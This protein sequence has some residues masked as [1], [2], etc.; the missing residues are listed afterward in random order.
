MKRFPVECVTSKEALNAL[1]YQHID[2]LSLDVEGHEFEVLNGFDWNT[3]TI[4]VI[5]IDNVNEEIYE[6]LTE[7]GYDYLQTQGRNLDKYH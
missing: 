5:E 6:L 3:T 7:L 4:S 1:G 2:F